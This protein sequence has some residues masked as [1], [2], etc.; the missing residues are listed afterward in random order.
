MGV[1]RIGEGIPLG[2]GA[3]EWA[4]AGRPYPGEFAS[5]DGYAVRQ[6]N[7]GLVAAVI[8]G[9]GHGE[10]A[11]EAAAVAADV[12]K[13]G[14]LE[15]LSYLFASAHQALKRTRGAVVAAAVFAPATNFLEWTGIGNIEGI[16]VRAGPRAHPRREY[17]LS[18]GGV[19]GAEPM[20]QLRLERL[21]V[22][23]GDVLVLATDGIASAFADAIDPNVAP[24]ALV[25]RILD[26]YARDT[27]DALVLVAQY[28]VN[29]P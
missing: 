16:L 19:L 4:V 28:R 25:G 12:F 24:G 18:R 23:P 13:H 11:A 20:P 14:G 26:Q 22:A 15:S 8:D 5:G 27:D 21:E 9:L 10:E 6:V 7:G 3:V 17:L 1:L 29:A 2:S